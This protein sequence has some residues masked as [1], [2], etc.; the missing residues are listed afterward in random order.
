MHTCIGLQ[1]QVLT[2]QCST[3]PC[4]R[5]TCN[6]C[7]Q[8]NECPQDYY[9]ALDMEGHR[10]DRQERPELGHGSVEFVAPAEYMVRT[11]LTHS[12]CPDPGTW[13]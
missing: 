5:F 9:C 3:L 6:I 2:L 11:T 7:G 8:A 13:P 4:R 1:Q 12:S 10:Q